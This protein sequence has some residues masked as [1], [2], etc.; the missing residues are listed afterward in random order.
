MGSREDELAPLQAMMAAHNPPRQS[1]KSIKNGFFTPIPSRYKKQ[2]EQA[3]AGGP[4]VA[5]HQR[6]V[7]GHIS[8][9]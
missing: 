1:C 9:L 7:H 5:A 8:L 4:G 2:S 3:A 6:A